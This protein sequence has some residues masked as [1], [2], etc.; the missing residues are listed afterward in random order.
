MADTPNFDIQ[1]AHKFF[2]VDCFNKTWDNMDKDGN[3]STEENMEMLHTAI[4]SLWHW[5]QREDVSRQNLSVG[6]WQVSRVYNLINQPHNARRY[7]LLSLQQAKELS[8]FYKGYAYETLARAEMTAGKRFIM[9]AYLEKAREM[10]EQIQDK[11]EKE[12]LAKDLES[13][14]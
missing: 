7:G 4:A 12:A 2:S 13:I 6:Y 8:P 14:N 9:L 1:Q 10:L 11:E 3:R 5:T